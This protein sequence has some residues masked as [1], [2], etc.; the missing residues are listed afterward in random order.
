MIL[1]KVRWGVL[2][3]SK[4]GTEVAIPAMQ[5]GEWAEVL[6]I[7][8]R[9]LGKAQVAAQRLGLP[10]AYGS[11][12]ELL[13]D[14]EVE[15]IYN[16]LPNHLH[17]P[18]SIRALEAG[19][20]VLCEK[21]IARTA[22]EASELLAAAQAHPRLKVMEGFMYRF[23]PQWERVRALVQEGSIGVLRAVH[24]TFSF[25]NE[26]PADIRNRTEVGGGG[27][28]DIGCYAVSVCRWLFAAEPRRVVATLEP[29]PRFG[30]DRRASAI[31]EFDRG[32]GSFTVATQLA[33]YQRV[34]VHGTQGWID[35][36]IPFN[37]PP[38]QPTRL[39]HRT[40]GEVAELVIEAADQDTI[41][42]DRFSEAV[43]GGRPLPTPLTDAVANMKVID[44]V[45]ASAAGGR[46]VDCS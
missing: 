39:V 23:H 21:P 16:P 40:D 29:D 11:Y 15:A 17:V 30:T 4:F 1:K 5:K 26:N 46:W 13:A 34:T 28:L 37:P 27:M 42:A 18:W 31:L 25:F 35:V 10:K 43:R 33:P 14:P 22:Q 8:S 6:A 44:A 38:D 7:A 9:D 24:A 45:L 2:S 12:E 19:K 3:T 41:Q 32:I 36:E 20:H